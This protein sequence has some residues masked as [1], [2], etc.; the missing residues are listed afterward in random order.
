MT[1]Q[2]IH[3][4]ILSDKSLDMIGITDKHLK[5]AYVFAGKTFKEKRFIF[6]MKCEPTSIE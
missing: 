1:V 5:V 3:A 4:E 6:L 2:G